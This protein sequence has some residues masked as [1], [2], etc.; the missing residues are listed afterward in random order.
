[1]KTPAAT[2]SVKLD[3][4]KVRT[5]VAGLCGMAMLRVGVRE[6]FEDPIESG[7]VFWGMMFALFL[8]ERW[9]RR[10]RRNGSFGNWR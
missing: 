3:A 1:M 4:K 6:V 10:M 2:E 8:F 5:C 9:L 7:V